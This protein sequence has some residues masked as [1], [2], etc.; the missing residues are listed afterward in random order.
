[1]LSLIQHSG[2]QSRWRSWSSPRRPFDC[3]LESFP[4]SRF[5]ARSCSL[6]LG[7]S[8]FNIIWPFLAGPRHYTTDLH[9]HQYTAPEHLQKINKKLTNETV[10]GKKVP[11]YSSTVPKPPTIYPCRLTRTCHRTGRPYK[12][13]QNHSRSLLQTYG[14]VISQVSE[15]Q[16]NKQSLRSFRS[17]AS[18]VSQDVIHRGKRIDCRHVIPLVISVT[19][20]ILLLISSDYS[21]VSP[22]LPPVKQS[23]CSDG[24]NT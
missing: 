21:H 8:T 22:P 3:R 17:A 6:K 14:L 7:I 11:F 15:S 24:K 2:S 13:I 5:Q 10:P 1:M 23:T 20:V 16:C 9:W 12:S 18:A 19:I 4:H